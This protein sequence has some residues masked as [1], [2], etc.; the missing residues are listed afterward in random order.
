MEL[1]G[2]TKPQV[3]Y[4]GIAAHLRLDLSLATAGLEQAQK[5]RVFFADLG[6]F[7]LQGPVA[8]AFSLEAHLKT[9]QGKL[10]EHVVTTPGVVVVIQPQ[11]A[12]LTKGVKHALRLA[13]IVL[14]TIMLQRELAELGLAGLYRFLRGIAR[15]GQLTH[16]RP[17]LLGLLASNVE[18]VLHD[19]I[20]AAA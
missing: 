9:A 6:V 10:R 5:G 12:S 1:K 7:G 15:L 2:G 13:G 20:G 16:L 11:V 8:L 19:D 17:Q 14:E 3:Q 18:V 4:T